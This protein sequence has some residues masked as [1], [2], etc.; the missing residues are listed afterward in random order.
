M[1]CIFLVSMTKY[2]RNS[3]LKEK[4]L[5]LH[6]VQGDVVLPGAEGTPAESRALATWHRQEAEKE[7]NVHA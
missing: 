4:G 1:F 2:P 6:T 5:T 3:H 7:M